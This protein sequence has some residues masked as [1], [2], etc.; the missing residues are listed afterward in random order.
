MA[1]DWPDYL[2]LA[3][4]L[5]QADEEA[6]QR[7]AISRAYYAAFHVARRHVERA[8]PEVAL[9]RHGAVHDVVWT[10]L[11]QGRREERA[12]AHG[13]KRLRQK[14]TLA[15]YQL[16]GLSFPNDARQALAWAEAVIRSL[17]AVAE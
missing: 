3:R 10:T 2:D 7:S 1:F 12:A 9:P 16:A 13:G 4:R 17:G 6:S 14:R 8:H 11:E 15:D 5:A